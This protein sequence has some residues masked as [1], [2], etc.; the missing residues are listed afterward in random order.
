MG[1]EHALWPSSE[2]QWTAG[3]QEP[4]LM[5]S[6]GEREGA[7]ADQW[8]LW[9]GAE[10]VTRERLSSPRG[11]TGPDPSLGGIHLYHMQIRSSPAPASKL[12]SV[13]TVS[14]S[15]LGILPADFC[16]VRKTLSRACCQFQHRL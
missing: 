12:R 1:T 4:Q 14:S 10:Q 11:E 2:E 13:E 16:D 6:R 5:E 3:R 7:G 8:G 9:R 15:S